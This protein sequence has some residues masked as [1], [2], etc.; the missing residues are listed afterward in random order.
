MSFLT[1]QSFA[2]VCRP[3]CDGI[4][5]ACSCVTMDTGEKCCG[6]ASDKINSNVK[7]DT[8]QTKGLTTKPTQ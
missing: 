1:V 8:N 4:K 5:G 2:G 3:S 7:T 6:S